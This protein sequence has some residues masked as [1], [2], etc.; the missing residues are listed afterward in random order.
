MGVVDQGR[1]Q[2]VSPDVTP[3]DTAVNVGGERVV[4]LPMAEWKQAAVR[5]TRA[6]VPAFLVVAAGGSA[7]SAATG[8]GIPP[9]LMVGLPSTGV[10]LVDSLI[11]VLI[12]WLLWFLWNVIEFA[13]D[14][15]TNAPRLRA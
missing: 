13:L 8:S 4:L 11:I 2:V 6:A 3:R 9:L 7:A 10:F 1:A 12:I 5:A 14:L 15:D